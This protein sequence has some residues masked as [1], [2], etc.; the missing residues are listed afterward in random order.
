[1]I[2]AGIDG[3]GT[4]CRIRIVSENGSILGEAK[5]KPANLLL[6]PS[7]VAERVLEVFADAA[8]AAGLK[9]ESYRECHLGLALASAEMQSAAADF[10]DRNWPFASVVLD[11]DAFGALMGAFRGEDGSIQIVGTGSCGF[12]MHEGKSTQIGGHEFPISD[13]AGG[14]WWG[15]RSVQTALWALDEIVKPTAFTESVLEKFRELSGTLNLQGR[16]LI[17]YIITWSKT[18]IP[19][20]YGRFAR[21]AFD[22]A[23][24]G[25]PYAEKILQEALDDLVTILRAHVRLGSTRIAMMGSI[26]IRIAAKLPADL[27]NMIQE[28]ESDAIDGA[29]LMARQSKGRYSYFT[30]K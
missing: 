6:G 8:D 13:Q 30:P 19:G 2:Y 15:L 23:E 28:P 4:G 1:M 27:R 18:A 7:M 29:I 9:P 21:L 24:N 3:G 11:T 25:D 17:D 14:A 10:M 26:G 22:S 12:L 16:E 5:G 20:D